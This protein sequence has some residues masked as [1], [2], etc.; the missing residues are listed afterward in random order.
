MDKLEAVVAAQ[1]AIDNHNAGL[2]LEKGNGAAVDLWHLLVSLREWSRANAV[3][4]NETVR[5]VEEYEAET[6]PRRLDA[7]NAPPDRI[8]PGATVNVEFEGETDEDGKQITTVCS[9]YI[10][11]HDNNLQPDEEAEIARAIRETG[12]Y[13]GGGGAALVWTLKLADRVEA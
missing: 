13:V 1:G 9:Y 11:A 7:A 8:D 12:E 3:N 10:F 5:Q 6:A 2:K 4:W